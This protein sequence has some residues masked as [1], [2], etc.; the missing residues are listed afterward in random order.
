[1]AQVVFVQPKLVIIVSFTRYLNQ[2]QGLGQLV[3]VVFDECHTIQD[4]QADFQPDMKKASEAMVQR[5]VQMIY[6]TATLALGDMPEFIEVIKVKIPED[7]IFQGSTS[8]RNNVDIVVEHQG[9]VE[10]A[11]AVH[12]LVAQKLEEYLA[13]AKI[14]IYCSSIV[15]IKSLGKE[16]D[17]PMYYAKV[18]SEAEKK[19]I[20][21][22]WE[23]GEERVVVVSNA[24][25][26]GIN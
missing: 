13:P 1:M 11:H 20:R 15:G 4:S 22:Q 10:E 26:L 18:G 17:C 9:D 8:Q 5:G 12:D 7:N 19:Q 24:F 6:L 3:Q 14:I 16:L 23:S 2:L 21:Q 25:R